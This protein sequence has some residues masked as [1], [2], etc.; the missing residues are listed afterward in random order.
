MGIGKDTMFNLSTSERHAVAVDVRNSTE[1]KWTNG[2]L[3]A[4]SN[5]GQNLNSQNVIRVSLE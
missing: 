5:G 3:Q 1:N 4:K 2:T